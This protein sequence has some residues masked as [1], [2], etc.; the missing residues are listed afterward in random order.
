MLFVKGIVFPRTHDLLELT[1]RLQTAGVA[2][3]CPTEPIGK[4]NPYAVLF[5]CDNQDFDPMPLDEAKRTAAQVLHWAQTIVAD[6][7]V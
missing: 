1:N 6:T 7:T 2:L 5:R 4:L 3:S